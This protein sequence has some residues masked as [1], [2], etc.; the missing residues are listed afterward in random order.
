MKKILLA[1]TLLIFLAGCFD[2]KNPG[3]VLTYNQIPTSVLE[4]IDGKNILDDE[5]IIA[6]YDITIFLNNSESAILTNKNVIYYKD[7]RIMKIPLNEIQ[8][9]N[10]DKDAFGFY[11][12]VAPING[13]L[14]TIEIA[15]M[16]GGDL[17]LDLLK[18][19]VKRLL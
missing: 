18:K 8:S 5:E 4:F 11:I 19:E 9:I 2:S 1:L 16:N 7:G 6:Y 13:Q 12:Y 14:M 3:G 17:F 10:Q 15:H